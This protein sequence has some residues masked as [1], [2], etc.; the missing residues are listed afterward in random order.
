M[1]DRVSAKWA[2]II[3]K[4]PWYITIVSLLVSA[5][6]LYFTTKLSI[7]SNFAALLP[8]NAQSVIDLKAISK[9][10]GGM[11]TLIIMLEGDDLKAMERFADDIAAKIRK[12]PKDEVR[13][14]DYK[15]DNLK[16]FFEHNKFLYPSIDTLKDLRDRIKKAAGKQKLKATGFLLDFDDDEEEEEDQGEK[17]D[18]DKE[19]AKYDKHL[20]KFDRF[21][22]GYLTNKEG[23][24][25]IV[26][27]KTPGMATGVKFA[28]R[29]L[30]KVQADIDSLDPA[31][32][33]KDMQVH[34]TGDLT[35]VVEEYYSLRDD[36]LIVSNICVLLVLLAVILYY[37][38]LRMAMIVSIGLVSSLFVT[39]GI[40]YLK[41][42]YLT[43]STAFLASIV[44]G[45]GINPGIY[46]LA[47]YREERSKSDDTERNLRASMQ[48]VFKSV[49]TAMAAAGMSYLS[50]MFVDFRGFNQ[51][52]FIGG[53]GM[54]ISIV[55][56][57][58]LD[59]AL[60]VLIERYKPFR[61]V[62]P[63]QYKRGRLFSSSAAWIVEHHAKAVFY[64]GVAMVLISAVMLAIFLRD[65]FEYNFRKLRNQKSNASGSGAYSNKAEK[66][67]GE[68]SSPYI[69]LADDIDD[70]PKIK[71]VL[72]KH[73]RNK[74]NPKGVIKS[75]KTVFDALPGDEQSQREK[76]KVLAEIRELINEHSK[77]FSK[78]DKKKVE[79]ITPPK[80]LRPIGVK[81]LPGEIIRMFTEDTGRIGT[82]VYVYMADGMSVWNGHDLQRFAKVVREIDLPNGKKVRSSGQSVI[83]ADMITFISHDGPK[84][85]A[86]GFF[87]VL[88]V[89]ILM[90][91]KLEHITILTAAMISGVVLMLGVAIAFGQKLN[92]LNFIAI[93]IQFG[94]GVDYSVNIYSRFLEEGPG[95]IGK[96]LRRTG[97]A[98][99]ITSA[100]TIIGYS[101]LWFSMNGAI[102]TFGT[103]AN[104]GE[105]TCLSV[106]VLFLPA[107]LAIFK[108]GLPN[109]S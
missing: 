56:A 103:L 37:R 31:K 88:L 30:K 70:V 95:S 54:F 60:T 24:Q 57:F 53:V 100:T 96:V 5:I 91:R 7:K 78:Y 41:I 89:I 59:P 86:I 79:R 68:R 69:I 52:G 6:G 25:L 23:T 34:L 106:A 18:L 99:M 93:P 92:F 73:I 40:T 94:I 62:D 32:Y 44:A 20:N 90:F 36:I 80:D 61:K 84:A 9:R 39:F 58:T 43:I 35:T 109:V 33:S 97:G 64:T 66:I 67:L 71:Q 46:F 83:F 3:Y 17:F 74:Q 26:V 76:I 63:M 15:I 29:M 12:Y 22:D 38:S 87:M 50:L 75:I 13:F 51:F 45:N 48:G 16:E 98:V 1:L 102:N 28:K 65:P 104:I 105:V 81:D 21:I 2:G 4:Y 11:G 77:F 49:L 47:R 14:V 55:Y 108:K 72:S 107:Y 27:V 42:G 82:P 101:A 8:E 19:L 10:M 85:T